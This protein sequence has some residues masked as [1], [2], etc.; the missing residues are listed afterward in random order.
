MSSVDENFDRF[1]AGSFVGT[2]RSS[3]KLDGSMPRAINP[4]I[5]H[6]RSP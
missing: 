4:A 2:G 5:K 3:T 1:G 6:I